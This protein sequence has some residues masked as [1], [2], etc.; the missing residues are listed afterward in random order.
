MQVTKKYTEEKIWDYAFMFNQPSNRPQFRMQQGYHYSPVYVNTA[1]GE[2]KWGQDFLTCPDRIYCTVTEILQGHHYTWFHEQSY[3]LLRGG[4]FYSQIWSFHFMGL[5]NTATWMKRLAKPYKKEISTEEPTVV[6]P[7]RKTKTK[8]KQN[9]AK[10]TNKTCSDIQV[11]LQVA[12]CVVMGSE[13]L[14]F[15]KHWLRR[16]TALC[17]TQLSN[18]PQYVY[19]WKRYKRDLSH[20]LYIA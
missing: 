4:T 5:K 2:S 6:R 1:D 18:F 10:Q 7:M 14:S 12:N 13:V 19:L 16:D 11:V 3:E 17:L 15:F 20:G 9:T 8:T